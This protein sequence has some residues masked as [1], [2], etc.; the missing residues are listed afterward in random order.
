MEGAFPLLGMSQG[1]PVAIAYAV[2]HPERV[3]RLILYGGYARGPLERGLDVSE[4]AS[5]VRVPT[6]V[7]HARGDGR[8]PHEEGRLLAALIPGAR[9]VS[10]DSANHVLLESEP[11]WDRFLEEVAGFL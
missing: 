4:L 9:F 10:L 5:E 6:L 3:S 1:A 8:V 7:L 2:R 11:A